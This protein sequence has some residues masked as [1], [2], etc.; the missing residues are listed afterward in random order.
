MFKTT[1]AWMFIIGLFAA[2]GCS[3]GGT[4]PDR[5]IQNVDVD[6]QAENGRGQTSQSVSSQNESSDGSSPE[7]E[8]PEEV[9][10]T[11]WCTPGELWTVTGDV[12]MKEPVYAKIV[13]MKK[14]NGKAYCKAVED[15]ETE[16]GI[17]VNMTHYFNEDQ[18]RISGKQR[19]MDA[20]GYEWLHH[21]N[22]FRQRRCGGNAELAIGW[23]NEEK[24]DTRT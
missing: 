10:A 24:G 18:K 9:P 19:S 13:G 8:S 14:Y 4:S 1:I 23:R 11:A 2:G 17:T 3:A 22:P 15:P 21:Q 20:N 12:K 7:G 16:N 6:S 5:A